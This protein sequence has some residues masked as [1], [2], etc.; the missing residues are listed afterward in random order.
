MAGGGGEPEGPSPYFR[1]IIRNLSHKQMANNARG[2]VKTLS[3]HYKNSECLVAEQ[4]GAVLK[5]LTLQ[6]LLCP[7]HCSLPILLNCFTQTVEGMVRE[8]RRRCQYRE[9][10]SLRNV[11]IFPT[12]KCG[13]ISCQSPPLSTYAVTDVRCEVTLLSTHNSVTCRPQANYTDRATA[14]CRRS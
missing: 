10:R 8:G 4:K 11:D 7:K 3:P 6:K 14:A 13:A 2:P 1:A 5:D 12:R 9:W